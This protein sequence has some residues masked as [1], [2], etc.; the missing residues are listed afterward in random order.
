MISY[1]PLWETMRRKG[2]TTYALIKNHSFSRGT[3]DSLKQGRNISTST[4]N[5]LC[6][7]LGCRVEDI[8]Q[9]RPDEK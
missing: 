2:V 8:L 3:L 7:T 4:L 9:Y 5:D 1:E 6:R